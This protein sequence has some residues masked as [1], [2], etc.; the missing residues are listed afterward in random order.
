MMFIIIIV[1]R[2]LSRK[3]DIN[4]IKYN[5]KY[6]LRLVYLI[7]VMIILSLLMLKIIFSV[8]KFESIF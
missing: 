2:F 5:R 4:L 1:Y 3:F 6:Y 7:I 8:Y